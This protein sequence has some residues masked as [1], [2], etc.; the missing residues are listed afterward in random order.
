MNKGGFVKVGSHSNIFG[1]RW[2]QKALIN[3]FKDKEQ[4]GVYYLSNSNRMA[5]M[6]W[7]ESQSMGS[8]NSFINDDGDMVTYMNG[9]NDGSSNP[10]GNG[11][12]YGMNKSWKTGAR[13]ANKF[14][15]RN[16]AINVNYSFLRST[17]EK[18]LKQFTEQLLPGATINKTD[19]SSSNFLSNGHS[20][21]ATYTTDIDSLISLT[22]NFGLQTRNTT[23]ASIYSTNN[24]NETEVP[25]SF[26]DRTS[27]EQGKNQ[28]INNSINIKKKF[29]KKDRTLSYQLSHSYRSNQK[30]NFILSTNALDLL[31]GGQTINLDQKMQADDKYTNIN[32]NLVYTEPISKYLKV[33]LSYEYIER[34]N[35]NEHLTLD[36]LGFPSKNYSNQVD[37]LSN[38]FLSK[39]QT[40]LPGFVF[41][42][43]K[44][45]WRVSLSSD[46][47]FTSF[48]QDDLLRNNNFDYTQTNFIPGLRLKYK[49]S[50]YRSINISYSG[51]TQ[52]PSANQ[53][54]PFQNNL[55]PLD[56][57]IGNPNLKLSYRQNVRIGYNSYAPIE[58]RNT[59]ISISVNNTINQIGTARSFDETGRT[60][61]TY[62][63]LPNAY[64]ANFYSYYSHKIGTTNFRIGLDANGNYNYSPNRINNIDGHS[65]NL[66]LNI[67][68]RISYYNK[69]LLSIR[70]YLEGNL[71]SNK[72]I[73]NVDRTI[74]YLAYS[75]S[76]TLALFLPFFITMETDVTY[77][78][79]PAVAPYNTPFKRLFATGGISK[80]MLRDRSLNI[81]FTMFDIFNQNQG[82]DR[83][84]NVNFNTE[85]FYNTIGRYWMIGATWNLLYGPANSKKRK[86]DNKTSGDGWRK[87]KAAEE[88]S[89]K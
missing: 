69:D 32:S 86:G 21:N 15:K 40:H 63:N 37:S 47:S 72:N 83:T 81:E 51:R 20:I 59:Y 54:Q 53:L 27:N 89:A 65:E 23:I 28:S 38:I 68:P 52:T 13:Y 85:S 49:F 19:K 56:I 43:E 79:T 61:T 46:V 45:K 10:F 41:R 64:G 62:L 25:I 1:D 80:K 22:Y 35:N 82:Y 74:Q 29:K 3:R 50:K 57:R 88:V 11:A 42:Y 71:V 7:Q 84:S 33:K 26:N 34:K 16:Q 17:R 78:Y 67:T 18:E 70:L 66:S 39:Q 75:P 77:N 5:E 4:M 87:K 6:S 60:T 9:T 14:D 2:E 12:Q 31:N 30:D 48:E 36:T 55:N 73:G 44:D 8:N 24:T 58:G 76:G